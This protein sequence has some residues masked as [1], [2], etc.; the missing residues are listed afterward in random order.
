ML[1]GGIRNADF[2]IVLGLAIFSAIGFPLGLS[3]TKFFEPSTSQMTALVLIIILAL[4]QLL[5]KSPAFLGTRPG[6]Y[7]AGLTAGVVTGLASLGGMVV[8][9]YVLAQKTP[10]AAIRG[11]LVMYLFIGMFTSGTSLVLMDVMTKTAFMRG[12]YYWCAVRE[13]VV[14]PHTRSLVQAGMPAAAYQPRHA[15]H[16]SLDRYS[17]SKL[18]MASNK[19]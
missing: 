3:A 11:S 14:R 10:I 4:M 9:L 19:R 15:G 18:T 17:A 16:A 5:K 12:S 1:R 13:P 7:A 6:L 8:A 2:R